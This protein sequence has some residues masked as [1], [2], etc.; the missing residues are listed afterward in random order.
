MLFLGASLLIARD[1]LKD[2]TFFLSQIPQLSL[3]RTMFPLGDYLKKD[4]KNMA[5]EANLECIAHK[6]ESMG[7]C[8]IGSRLFQDFIVEV[9]FVT[10]FL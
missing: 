9:K 2:Q 8:F 5:K 7:I 10:I 3:R 6:K 4:V 1:S